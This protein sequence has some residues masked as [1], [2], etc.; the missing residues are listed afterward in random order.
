[1]TAYL[2]LYAE[3]EGRV[4][5]RWMRGRRG[6]NGEGRGALAAQPRG[7]SITQD[8]ATLSDAGGLFITL[9]SLQRGFEVTFWH[10]GIA[11]SSTRLSASRSKDGVWP[12]PS[13]VARLSAIS[14]QL[15][16][17]EFAPCTTVV[18]L[19]RSRFR[20]PSPLPSSHPSP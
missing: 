9:V 1:M 7:S 3:E 18:S 19:S 17:D 16:K 8:K 6:W 2:R 14:C 15:A 20:F 12:V 10:R 11:R 13:C 5:W 4:Q